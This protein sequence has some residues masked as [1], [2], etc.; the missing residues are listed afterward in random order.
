[1]TIDDAQDNYNLRL[2]KKKRWKVK[3]KF[4]GKPKDLIDYDYLAKEAQFSKDHK[5]KISKTFKESSR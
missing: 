1:M 2:S 5:R 3:L 4:S